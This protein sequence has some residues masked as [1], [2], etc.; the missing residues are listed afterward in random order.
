MKKYCRSSRI[1]PPRSHETM[2]GCFDLFKE[3][4][5]QKSN[6]LLL[7]VYLGNAR[8]IIDSIVFRFLKIV[9]TFQHLFQLQLP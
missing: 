2:N 6:R 8:K 1:F 9:S 4:D 7:A 3:M 5:R